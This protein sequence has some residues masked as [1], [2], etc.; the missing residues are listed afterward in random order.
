MVVVLS[1]GNTRWGIVDISIDLRRTDIALHQDVLS[2]AEEAHR[3]QQPSR[4]KVM[5]VK[6]TEGLH[7][8]DTNRRRSL[9]A[10]ENYDK[11]L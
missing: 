11:K 1:T 6:C 5:E 3:L 4:I 8:L 9:F 10:W 7:V 2:M